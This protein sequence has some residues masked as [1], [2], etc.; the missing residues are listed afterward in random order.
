MEQSGPVGLLSHVGV[1]VLDLERA[2]AFYSALLGA[3][4]VAAWGPYVALK[5]LSN[6][7]IFYLQW[8]P[9]KKTGKNQVHFDLSVPD[10]KAAV[11]R[12]QALGG[13]LLSEEYGEP[14]D[15]L[16]VFADPDDNVFCLMNFELP[17]QSG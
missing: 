6:G 15:G 16:A 13:R 8:V 9:E 12:V 17:V 1:D 4:R 3:K 10:V 5:P 7:V 2:E 11:P 14:T